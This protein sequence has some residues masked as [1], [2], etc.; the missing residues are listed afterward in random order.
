MVDTM[1]HNHSL[2]TSLYFQGKGTIVTFFLMGKEGFDK[3]L[4][5]LR[6]ALPPEAHE[7]K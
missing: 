3:P 2:A 6:D 7:F 5:D 1:S 4:P